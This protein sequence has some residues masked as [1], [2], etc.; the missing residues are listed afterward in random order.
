QMQNVSETV[1]Y[2]LQQMLSQSTLQT[3]KPQVDAD[4]ISTLKMLRDTFEFCDISAWLP[5]SCFSSGEGITFFNISLPNGRVQQ[6]EVLIAPYNKLTWISQ[7]N[8]HYP[9]MRFSNYQTRNLLSCFIRVSTLSAPGAFCFFID[10]D[11]RETAALL[12]QKYGS[13]PIEQYMINNQGI[14]IS[15]T[16]KTRLG[17]SLESAL[18]DAL[19]TDTT[20]QPLTYQQA[21]YI[22]YPLGNTNWSL[23]VSVP[24]N[25]LFNLSPTS[26]SG[27]FLAAF[28]AMFVSVLASILISRQLMRK[29]STMSK[30]IRS[31]TPCFNLNSESFEAI[32]ARVPVPPV[33]TPPD[34]LDELAIAFNA[35]VDKLN[36]TMQTALTSSLTHEKLRY[37]LLRAKINP[38]FLYNI[39]DSIKI[40]NT[41]G[42]SNDANLML[43]KLAAFYRLILRKN[44]LDI[45]LINEELEIVKLYLEM[46][47]IGHEH[48][49]SYQYQIDPDIGFFSIPR[50]VLQPLVENCVTHGLPGDAKHMN[51]ILRMRYIGDAIRIEIEDDGLGIV[52]AQMES[53]LAVI[54]GE[55]ELTDHSST[56]FYGLNNISK[57]LKPY[58]VNPDEPI[59]YQSS[60]GNGTRV[61]IDLKQLLQDES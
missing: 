21:V 25:Y 11:E 4:A 27:I 43:S 56:A 32:H 22:R 8:Y 53:L 36:G 46:E 31:I 26:I 59:C 24:K 61:T 60:A 48:S 39:L 40:C 23:V 54:H 12:S 17:T 28:I 14:I 19:T 58:V 47:S 16:D 15:H 34:V 7:T 38:H 6:P 57:R 49:F 37:R 3:P 41:L 44:D 35:L 2:T 9:F 13:S 42:R 20:A 30:V 29:L 52:P 55:T 51:I 10:I 45:I 18:M 50:F 33:G 1:R 5:S